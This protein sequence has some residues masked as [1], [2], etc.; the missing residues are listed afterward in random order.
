MFTYGVY[1]SRPGARVYY[2]RRLHLGS[3]ALAFLMS[4]LFL[5]F[6]LTLILMIVEHP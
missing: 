2:A 1:K 4:I 3:I 6:A 5:F